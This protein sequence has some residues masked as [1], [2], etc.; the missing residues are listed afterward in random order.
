MQIENK[1]SLDYDLNFL[2]LASENRKKRKKKSVHTLLQPPV[3]EYKVPSKI[4]EGQTARFVYV[5]PKFS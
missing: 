2:N 1:S 4:K 3:W 5:L